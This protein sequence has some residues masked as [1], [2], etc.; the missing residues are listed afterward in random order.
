M[1][2][3]AMSGADIAYGAGLSRRATQAPA[4]PIRAAPG[5]TRLPAYE[6]STKRPVLTGRTALYQVLKPLREGFAS[7]QG[8]TKGDYNR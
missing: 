4:Y 5:T 7:G 1:A 2:C 3:C 8:Q 6:R